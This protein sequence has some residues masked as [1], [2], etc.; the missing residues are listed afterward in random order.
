MSRCSSTIG[1][2]ASVARRRGVAFIA[3]LGLLMLLGVLVAGVAASSSVGQR[4]TRLSHSDAILAASADYALNTLLAQWK[5]SLLADLPLGVATP[6]E[7]VVQQSVPVRVHATATRL[8]GGVLWLTAD[9]RID[10]VDRGRRRFGVV[11]RFPALGPA[12]PAGLIARGNVDVND[13]RFDSDTAGDGDCAARAAA[14]ILVAPGATWSSSDSVRGA[15]DARAADSATFFMT[16]RQLA[17]LAIADGARI[18]AGDTTIAGG[19]YKGILLVDG[20]LRIT[21]PF[22]ATGV[23][24]ARGP[25]VADSVYIEGAMLSFAPAPSTA[26]ALRAGTIVYSPCVIARLLRLA[27]PPRPVRERSWSEIF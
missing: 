26:I 14:T 23:V 21:A 19:S 3:A 7:S 22:V 5:E 2:D 11:A 10:D 24:I 16:S 13:V 20:A 25:I 1:A 17:A 6:F 27:S 12:A 4:V 15:I 18:V 8:A 9:A